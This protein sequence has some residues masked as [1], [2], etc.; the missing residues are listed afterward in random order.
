[1]ALFKDNL[2]FYLNQKVRTPPPRIMVIGI[3]G[4]GVNTQ[5]LNLNKEFNLPIFKMKDNFLK[6]IKEQKLS[7][8]Q[9]RLLDRGFKPEEKD[10]EG[11]VVED[12]EIGEEKEDFDK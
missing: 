2:D 3:H 6:L 5:L 11:N 1:L 10:E 8:K 4:S 7:R 9:Q 12:N